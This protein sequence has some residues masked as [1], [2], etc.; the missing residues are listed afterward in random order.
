MMSKT[1]AD[2]APSA[3]K[4]RPEEQLREQKTPRPDRAAQEAEWSQRRH[5]AFATSA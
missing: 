3:R 5:T 1:C 4:G 2:K